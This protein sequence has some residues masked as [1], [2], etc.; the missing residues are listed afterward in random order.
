[1]APWEVLGMGNKFNSLLHSYNTVK[2]MSVAYIN[3]IYHAFLCTRNRPLLWAM[4]NGGN[5]IEGILPLFWGPTLHIPFK[6]FC[7]PSKRK[8]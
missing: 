2:Q 8:G 7:N 3:C 1:M 6:I 4:W 5:K